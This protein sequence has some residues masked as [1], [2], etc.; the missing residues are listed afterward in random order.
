MKEHRRRITD[1]YIARG[2]NKVLNIVLFYFSYTKHK[3]TE[4][5][6]EKT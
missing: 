1:T 6:N 4:T 2:F 3:T 5:S